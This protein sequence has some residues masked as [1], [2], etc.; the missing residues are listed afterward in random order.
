MR[1][2]FAFIILLFPFAL[3][4]QEKKQPKP[5]DVMIEKYLAAEADKL[6]K[7]FLD[8]AKTIAQWKANRPRLYREYMDMLGL[9]PMPEKTPLKATVTGTVEAH[10]VVVEKVHFQSKPGLY[11]TANVYRPKAN[12]PSRGLSAAG[13]KYPAVVYVCGH[14]GRGRDG[15]KTA[16]QDHGFW[17]ANNGYVCIVLDTLQLGEIPGVHHG[18]YGRPWGHL[19]SWLTSRERK[20]PDIAEKMKNHNRFWWHSIGYSPAAVECWNGIRAIDY[21]LTRDDVDP[22]KIGVT[23]ISGGG[24]ATF[25]IAAADDR[26]KVAVPVSGMSDLEFYIKNKGINGHCDCMFL[27]NTYQWDW[28]TIAALVAPRP[29]LFANSDKDPIFPMDANRRIFAKL[30]KIYGMYRTDARGRKAAGLVQEYVSEGGHDYRTDL[31]LAIFRFFNK[32]LK[33]DAKAKVEDSASYTPLEGKKLRVFPTDAD[34]PKD[35]INHKID[36]T[37]ILAAKV[38]LPERGKFAEWKK[39][40]MV[41]LRHKVFPYF[42]QRIAPERIILEE[43]GFGMSVRGGCVTEGPVVVDIAYLSTKKPDP[44]IGTIYLSNQLDGISTSPPDAV[45]KRA[46]DRTVIVVGARGYG[47][48]TWTAKSPPNYVARSHVLLG[49]SVDEGRVWDIIA[50][51]RERA[52]VEPKRKHWRVVGE[53]KNGILAVYAALFEPSI[54]EVIVIDPPKSHKDG[55]H[56][57]NVMRVLDIPEALGLLAP[58]PLT[59]IGGKDRAFDRTAEIYRLAG[60]ADKLTRK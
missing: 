19:G 18:T 21:L 34:L 23:G 13:V 60:A 44:A 26:V 48:S 17:F 37:F 8:G 7:N 53:G 45:Q 30:Q 27:Y 10:G 56:F 32:H 50:T 47:E 38:T 6:S 36:E 20:G 2:L 33:G 51:V 31:R 12:A 28:T 15:V 42:T 43:I 46:G 9:W 49:K 5:G 14:S 55:P 57:L 41:V 11:V 39:G 29:M 54:K 35:A 16:F 3:G 40:K 52:E 22:E 24:A 25:W 4:A 59:I 1:Y 58:T